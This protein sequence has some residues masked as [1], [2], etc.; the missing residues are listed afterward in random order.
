MG[1]VIITSSLLIIIVL[2]IRRAFKGRLTLKL[3]YALW[4]LVVI[5][6]ILPFSFIDSPVSIMN[7]VSL[8]E[9]VIIATDYNKEASTKEPQTTESEADITEGSYI[10]ELTYD[11]D[12]LSYSIII[13]YI[14]YLGIITIAL[15]MV[16]SNVF[17]AR[18]LIKSR[19]E[20][21]VHSSR[22]PIYTSDAISSPCLFWGFK[23]TGIYIIPSLVESPEEMSHVI[24]HELSHYYNFDHFWALVRNIL[25]A[26]YWFNPLVW[27]AAYIS[28]QDCELACDEAAIKRIGEGERFAYG[29]TLISLI[30]ME[31]PVKSML[32]IATTM[33]TDK[34][35][36]KERI[37]MIAKR[38]KML[39]STFL[40]IM[41]IIVVAVGCTFTGGRNSNNPEKLASE[42]L[43]K[44]YEVD[45]HDRYEKLTEAIDEYIKEHAKEGGNLLSIG[46]EPF[47]EY[48]NLYDPYMTE[49]ALEDLFSDGYAYELDSLAYDNNFTSEAKVI[50]LSETKGSG[51]ATIYDY[52]VDLD[53]ISGGEKE[54]LELEGIIQLEKNEEGKY[55]ISFF[56]LDNKALYERF[57]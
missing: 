47:E 51:E 7:Y 33:N 55:K 53:I 32:S 50:H 13:K 19:K 41:L 28:R 29:R 49:K 48:N 24:A 26:V 2:F 46:P 3:Q 39:M 42:F 6:L 38:P 23:G 25:L 21:E 44:I 57:R 10:E 43:R 37:T 4:L 36:L 17:F 54:T 16:A 27:L 45:S 5:R 22:L 34:R 30:P 18:K 15:Y 52:R 1:E 31:K 35:S 9:E 11:S 20:V 12:E 8:P 56:T 40:S 14:W